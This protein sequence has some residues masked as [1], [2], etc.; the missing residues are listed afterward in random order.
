MLEARDFAY[1]NS[2]TTTYN[3]KNLIFNIGNAVKISSIV[4]DSNDTTLFT[5]NFVEDRSGY[6]V[7]DYIYIE[8]TTDSEF[9]TIHIIDTVPDNLSLTI[10]ISTSPNVPSDVTQA[11][12]GKLSSE[13]N[14]AGGGI[15]VVSYGNTFQ[16]LRNHHII[17]DYNTD[18]YKDSSWSFNRN[19][20]T[21]NT[22]ILKPQTFY[23]DNHL[24]YTRLLVKD[25]GELY[26]K[27]SNGHDFKITNS[28][29]E[30]EQMQI[31]NPWSYSNDN[32]IYTFGQLA[33][34]NTTTGSQYRMSVDGSVLVT[35][36]V[37]TE[38]DLNVKNS[39]VFGTN[40]KPK[41]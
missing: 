38:G 6:T 22:I 26:F 7:G 35:G 33:I 40:L 19:I 29:D 4:K 37:I 27:N 21:D 11:T 24:D 9:D 8:G 5:I 1:F 15:T 41:P 36:E 18:N 2:L 28:S 23:Y 30:D 31:F 20:K 3:D 12:I 14:S 10:K 34:G 32:T 17:Y 13:S 16:E 25:D 39:L